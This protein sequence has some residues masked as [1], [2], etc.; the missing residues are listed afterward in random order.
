MA[1]VMIA[2]WCG[3][4]Y[5]AVDS[6]EHGRLVLLADRLEDRVL[7]CAAWPVRLYRRNSL[8]IPRKT[9]RVIRPKGQKVPET[10]TYTLIGR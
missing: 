8:A 3:G 2:C 5:R 9:F 7:Y 1:K 6:E 10:W 4:S